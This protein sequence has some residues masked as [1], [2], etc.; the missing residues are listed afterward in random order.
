MYYE[1]FITF[2]CHNDDQIHHFR[3]I[4]S[5]HLRRLGL[6]YSSSIYYPPI[7]RLLDEMHEL[8]YLAKTEEGQP[9]KVREIKKNIQA[10]AQDL[11]SDFSSISSFSIEMRKVYKLYHQ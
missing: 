6:K 10:L 9:V 4:F 1:F 2:Y 8:D 7:E 3:T 5:A 11:K